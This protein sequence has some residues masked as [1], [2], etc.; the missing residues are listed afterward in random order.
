MQS[1]LPPLLNSSQYVKV[2]PMGGQCYEPGIFYPTTPR[3]IIRLGINRRRDLL[4]R[5]DWLVT[6]GLLLG[7]VVI[8]CVC[9]IVLVC[10]LTPASTLHHKS[11][12]FNSAYYLCVQILFREYGWPEKESIS[13][14]YRMLQLVYP[15][16]D[17]SSKGSRVISFRK[18]HRKQPASMTHDSIQPGNVSRLKL[19]TS[20]TNKHTPSSFIKKSLKANT[21]RNPDSNVTSTMSANAPPECIDNTKCPNTWEPHKPLWLT[22]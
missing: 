19:T 11:I 4:L 20:N 12:L 8:L 13:V 21:L 2:M 15:M 5:P 9:I 17:Y 22:A 7:A 14:Q 18:T 3:H 6:G 16:D 10:L 1:N